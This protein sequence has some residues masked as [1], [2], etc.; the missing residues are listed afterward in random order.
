MLEAG[1]LDGDIAVV[2]KRHA[3]L[4]GDFVVAIVDNEYTL[5]E[6]GKDKQGYFLIPHNADFS[7]IRPELSLEIFGVMVGLI[8]K[9]R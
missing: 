7:I 8:R 3:A 9:Y 1:I 6:L 5:K 4:V 2:E